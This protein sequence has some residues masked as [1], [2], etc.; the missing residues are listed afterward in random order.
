M[1]N[2]RQALAHIR[3]VDPLL[4]EAA[5][6]YDPVSLFEVNESKNYFERLCRSIAGQQLSTKAAA[7]IWSRFRALIR[8][9]EMTPKAVLKL[10]QEQMRGAGLSNAKSRYIQGIAQAAMNKSVDL[11]NL[12]KL[13]DEEVMETLI[14]LKGVG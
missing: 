5:V 4:Y 2:Y 7:T 8:S 13:N 10:T 9:K 1:K 6:R 12:D 3:K 14:Q 11:V